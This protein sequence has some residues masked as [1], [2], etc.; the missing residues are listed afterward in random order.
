MPENHGIGKLPGVAP[1]RR[2]FLVKFA[3]AVFAAPVISSFALDGIARAQP[4]RRIYGYG[5]QYLGN[6]SLPNQHFPNQHFPNQRFPNQHR[7]EE[8]EGPFWWLYG[9]CIPF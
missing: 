7:H 9:D 1:S 4:D 5:N 6:Q 8:C 3:G 2:S